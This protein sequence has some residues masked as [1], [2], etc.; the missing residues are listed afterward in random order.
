MPRRYPTK[1]DERFAI[2]DD[3][4]RRKEAEERAK[5]QDAE[6]E[7]RQK[8]KC[9]AI[10]KIDQSSSWIWVAWQH[11][12]DATDTQAEPWKWGKVLSMEQAR[13]KAQEAAGQDSH[14]AGITC[15]ALAE[16]ALKRSKKI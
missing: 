5:Q 13:Q 4:K 14:D 16:R 15:A 12:V 9:W 6:F 11:G 7:Y 2:E 1:A 8:Q 10:K 3:K